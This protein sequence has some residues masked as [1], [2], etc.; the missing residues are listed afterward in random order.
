MELCVTLSDLMDAIDSES[1]FDDYGYF[2]D[3]AT[4]ITHLLWDRE[5]DGADDPELFDA[6]SARI[7]SFAKLPDR[8]MTDLYERARAFIESV[9]ADERTKKRL[10]KALKKAER[11]KDISIFLGE[12]NA[13][14]L[15]EEQLAYWNA[16]DEE[17]VRAWCVEN[18]ITI[19]GA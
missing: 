9:V 15:Y 8:S 16:C 14:G 5:V 13:A 18:G 11:K 10:E 12:A 19:V 17:F 7:D 4:G 2:L 3:P 1:E 6:M